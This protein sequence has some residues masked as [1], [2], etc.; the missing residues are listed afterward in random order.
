MLITY[1]LES[2]YTSIGFF[3]LVE[4]SN[5]VFFLTSIIDN[6]FA[7]KK[8]KEEEEEKAR[9]KISQVVYILVKHL[10]LISSKQ[11]IKVIFLFFFFF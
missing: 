4:F 3:F 2:R 6:I 9:K 8:K 11:K 1:C 5:P 7:L 10:D